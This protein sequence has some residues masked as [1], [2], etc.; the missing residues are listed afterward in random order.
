MAPPAAVS[1][2]A[3]PAPPAPPPPAPH[4]GLAYPRA[5]T[6]NVVETHHGVAVPDPYRWLEDMDS[7][8]TRA[9][10]TQENALTD[11][12]F[13]KLPGKGA[14]R[15]RI[16]ELVSYESFRSPFHR[17][18]RY[19]WLHRDGKQDQPVLW[20]APRL[21]AQPTVLLDPN[22]ISTDGSLAFAGLSASETGAR[23][24]YGLS[25]GGG[26]WQ[27]WHIRDVATAKDLPDELSHIKYYQPAFTHD[28]TGLYYSRFPAPAPG[29]ELVETDHDCKVYFHRVGTP[30]AKDVVVYERADHPTWQFDLEVTHDGRYLVITTGDGEV[31][32]RGQELISYLDLQKPGK[33][34]V[35]LIETYDAEYVFA[36]ND[37]PVFYLQTTSG[38][39]RK[40]VIAIDTRTP[41]RDRW[42]VIVPEGPNAIESARLTGRQLFV[43]T[44]QDAHTAVTAY[45][46][47][48][49]KLRDIAL[50]GIGTS[51]GFGGGPDDKE[52]FFLF[53]SFTVPAAIYRENLATGTSTLWKAPA[54]PFDPS[55]FET[56]QVFFPSKDGTKVP[57]FI[58]AKKGLALDGTHPTV[59]TAYGFGGF[60]QTPAFDPP[61]IAW[62]ERG[63]VLG[64]VNIRG[65]GEYGEAWHRQAWKTHR[66]VAFDDFAAAG[67]WLV[68]NH[69]TS[70]AHL[71]AIGT[72]GGGFLVGGVMMQH[73]ELFG[74][75]VPIAGVHDLL[76]FQLFGQGAGWQGDFGSLDDPAE[77]A[78][79]RAVSPLHNVRA[80]T[81]YPAIFVTT[82]DHDVR[83]AP[84]HSYKLTA[85]LQAAQSGQ[86]PVVMRVE[87]ESGHGG[88]STRTQAIDQNTEI[89]TFLAANLGLTVK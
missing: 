17:G 69:Y 70:P 64:L 4:A 55:A 19:F 27:T 71:G 51:F 36:G 87:T 22:T 80:G 23:V 13:G 14:L 3:A 21:D 15:A 44:L 24:A 25:I 40:R 5:P 38:A 83:V 41:A 45:D 28:G 47:H 78:V 59:I 29:K 39:E 11:A 10:V 65:G 9:W 8:E 82:S 33:Q 86:A 43:T 49:K 63:G 53:T 85:A 30:A 2:P 67:E 68:A 73:P 6:G 31:G 61:M 72:S 37:G 62:L 48:G 7:A 84:L 42:Q 89:L 16:T 54:V 77:F 46:L 81:R 12:Y 20:T 66:Q 50:P 76:R 57:M 56:K 60:S 18:A 74:A 32:D 58:T 1:P 35:A 26:D 88:G 79:L 75:V 34:P 52:T